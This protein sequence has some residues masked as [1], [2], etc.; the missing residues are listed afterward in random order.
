MS[1]NKKRCQFLR[2]EF[3]D[4]KRRWSRENGYCMGLAVLYE[5]SLHYLRVVAAVSFT[6]P[7][8]VSRRSLL[9]TKKDGKCIIKMPFI[10]QYFSL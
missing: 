2:M 10:T 7:F 3:E 5:V 1:K 6:H 9:Y 8:V 4:L